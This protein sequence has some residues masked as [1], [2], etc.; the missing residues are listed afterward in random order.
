MVTEVMV[1]TAFG[2]SSTGRFP[3]VRTAIV[4]E[5]DPVPNVRPVSPSIHADT[6]LRIA[7]SR[8]SAS[9]LN[10]LPTSARSIAFTASREP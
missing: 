3:G 8:V 6:A 4:S 9:A 5:V 7:V 10:V 2:S 1:R